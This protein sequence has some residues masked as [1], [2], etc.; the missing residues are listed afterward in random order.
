MWS[1][2]RESAALTVVGPFR[3]FPD[4]LSEEYDMRRSLL[5]GVAALT[6]TGSLAVLLTAVQPT[7]AL[8]DSVGSIGTDPVGIKQP[9]G[10]YQPNPPACTNPPVLVRFATFGES[11][12]THVLS[13][14]R[15]ANPQAATACDLKA[16]SE[17]FAQM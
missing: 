10:S 15:L 8:A 11:S 9:P 4:P 17:I 12:G 2:R 13:L 7:P 1:Q 14:F 6:M 5:R 3:S 16:F